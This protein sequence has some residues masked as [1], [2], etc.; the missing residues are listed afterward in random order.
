M[1]ELFGQ[2]LLDSL[3]GVQNADAYQ[4]QHLPNEQVMKESGGRQFD[5]SGK[6]LVG[7]YPNGRT[8]PPGQEAYGVGQIQIGTARATAKR[9]GIPWNEARLL[10]DRDYNLQL[11]DLHKGDLKAKYGDERIAQAAYYSGEPTVD[12]AIRKYGRAGFEQGLGPLGRKYIAGVG[13]SGGARGSGA[14]S[15]TASSVPRAPDISTIRAS[16]SE[17]SAMSENRATSVVNP[18]TEAGDVER[19]NATTQERA[20]V[21]DQVLAG[22]VTASEEVRRQQMEALRTTVEAKKGI[23]EH[24]REVTQQLIERSRPIFQSRQAIA[25]RR[26]QLASMNPLEAALKGI[27]NPNYN[28]EYLDGTERALAGQVDALNQA[29]EQD[30]KLH[31]NLTN[32]AAA[33]Y[34]ADNEMFQLQLANHGEDVRNA[35]LSW[36]SGNRILQT[37][38]QGIQGNSAV[39]HAQTVARD[40]IM[41]GLSDGQ[42]NEAIARADAGT[43]ETTVN[44]VTLRK[45]DLLELRQN[46]QSRLLDMETRQLAIESNRQSVADKAEERILENMSKSEVQ[47]AIRDGGKFQGQ[48][49]DVVKLG[50]RLQQLQAISEQSVQQQMM[51]DSGHVAATM[52]NG[53]A[54]QQTSYMQRMIGLFGNTTPEFDSFSRGMTATLRQWTDG[55]KKAQAAGTASEF[56]ALN[57]PQLQAMT[58]QQTKVVD[59]SIKRWSG[60]NQHAYNVGRAWV[61]GEPLDSGSAMRGLIHF[62]RNGLPAGIQ[63]SGPSARVFKVVQEEVNKPDDTKGS[64]G[65]KENRLIQRIQGRVAGVYNS[66]VLNNIIQRVPVIAKGI[67]VN[68]KPHPL[69][70]VSQGDWIQA[71][72]DGDEIGYQR[73]ATQLNMNPADFKSMLAQGE[74]SPLWQQRKTGLPREQQSIGYWTRQTQAHQNRATLERLD[75]LR[76]DLGFRPSQA[77]RDLMVNPQFNEAATNEMRI[78]ERGSFGGFVTGAAAAGGLHSSFQNYADGVVAAYGAR[79]SNIKSITQQRA[80]ELKWDPMARMRFVL[81]AIDGLSDADERKLSSYIY[82]TFSTPT[83]LLDNVVD[84]TVPFGPGI[85]GGGDREIN[86]RI[87]QFILG[88]KAED[89]DIER[90]RKHAARQ[91]GVVAP[92]VGRALNRHAERE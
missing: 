36:E 34:A 9:H 71:I 60:G 73:A 3:T 77:L 82:K 37:E 47:Q 76:P 84:R 49:F 41:S 65:E 88:G 59:E 54:Q 70:R 29:Y 30:F 35:V 75:T 25:D 87:D 6:P 81:G 61:R 43:G 15:A 46:R 58:E 18:F 57:M 31:Q 38:L 8:P 66:N 1:A 26:V 86:S 64:A 85:E 62:A 12:R 69:S 56:M 92:T 89:P 42:L 74:S 79:A 5:K 40:E 63:M 2:R 27:F 17:I 22:A 28:R 45:P 55:L 72:H 16:A 83:N 50:G 53:I 91:W 90:I 80:E 23:S 67:M 33:D 52:L 14:G 32:L 19:A 39:I 21:A 24:Q 4:P 10:N 68:G 44:G 20:S 51:Q 7:R 48:Q 11:S 13:G 78:H